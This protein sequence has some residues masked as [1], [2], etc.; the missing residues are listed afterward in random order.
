M[1]F[2]KYLLGSGLEI[3][4]CVEDEIDVQLGFVPMIGKS[5]N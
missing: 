2:K 3:V 4:L 1:Y 5:S